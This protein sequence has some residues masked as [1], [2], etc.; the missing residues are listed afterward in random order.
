[1]LPRSM[2]L[3]MVMG[4]DRF[5]LT[6]RSEQVRRSNAILCGTGSQVV[7]RL[8]AG[9]TL[10]GGMGQ[11]GASVGQVLRLAVPRHH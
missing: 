3:N 9:N 2:Q 1:M 7:S 10:Q 4:T 5:S 6:V 8:P 11:L